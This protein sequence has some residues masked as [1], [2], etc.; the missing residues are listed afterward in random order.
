MLSKCCTS[1]IILPSGLI[2][3]FIDSAIDFKSSACAKTF[4]ANNKS[5]PFLIGL[6][7]LSSKYP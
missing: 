1:I 7:A 2:N 5:A 4:E 6:R 3:F